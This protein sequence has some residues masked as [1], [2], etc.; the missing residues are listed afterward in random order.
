MKVMKLICRLG[1]AA[2]AMALGLASPAAAQSWPS[3]PVTIVVPYAA[4]GGAEFVGR[5]LAE[6][7]TADLGQQVLIETRGGA[8][9][10]IGA[11]VVAK[12]PADG[13]TLMLTPVAP[14]VNAPFLYPDLPYDPESAFAP[15]TMVIESP[16]VMMVTDSF[17]A[18]D[19]KEYIAYAKQNPG[20]VSVG[21]SGPGSTQY[22]L[23]VLLEDSAGIDLNLVP[24]K[25]T[26]EIGPDLISGRLA[27]MFDFPG[28]YR[29]AID[30]GRVRV[31][32][33]FT[34]AKVDGYPD[35]PSVQSA[36]VS[37]LPVWSSWFGLYGPK[38]LPPEIVDRLNKSVGEFLAKPETVAKLATNSYVPRHSTPEQVSEQIAKERKI[39]A[40]IA[41]TGKLAP[42]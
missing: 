40:A 3:E 21:N 1:V 41:A 39:V 17:P 12:A 8:G 31:L 15:I 5:L 7:L 22:L 30:A 34:E 6:H 11:A 9:A 42:Q 32:A 2:T 29:G 28:P 13:Y 10:T 24:Y 4:G 16:I 14:I 38:G 33:N 18:K 26:G 19:A 23:D 36:G 20:A 35:L 37:T 27:S 25:G